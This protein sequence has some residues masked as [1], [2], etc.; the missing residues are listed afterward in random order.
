MFILWISYNF[1]VVVQF[2][3]WSLLQTLNGD[4]F[5]RSRKPC[6][7]Q[8]DLLKVT[9]RIPD[10]HEFFKIV[11][12]EHIAILSFPLG[13]ILAAQLLGEMLLDIVLY[14]NHCH[15]YWTLDMFKAFSRGFKIKDMWEKGFFTMPQLQIRLKRGFLFS[16]WNKLLRMQ[17]ENILKAYI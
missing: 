4:I 16:V 2:N 3:F 11:L 6:V 15:N 12:E 17:L 5:N 1:S 13:F 7:S 14:F 10:I 9:M 8:Y